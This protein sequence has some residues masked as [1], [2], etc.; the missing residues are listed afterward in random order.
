M[1]LQH[2]SAYDEMIGQPLK[3]SNLLEVRLGGA[4]LN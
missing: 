4:H 1:A 3:T 2:E